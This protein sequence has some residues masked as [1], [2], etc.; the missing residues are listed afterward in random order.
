MYLKI[1]I[2]LSNWNDTKR[3]KKVKLLRI[4]FFAR[5]MLSISVSIRTLKDTIFDKSISVLKGET[6]QKHN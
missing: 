1:K 4:F 6:G 2:I 5:T 3:K